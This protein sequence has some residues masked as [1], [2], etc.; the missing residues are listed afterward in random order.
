[1]KEEI[2]LGID[3]GTR[4]TGYGVIR[5][6]GSK[7]EL[8]DFGCIKP[9]PTLPL[10][11]RYLYLFNGVEELVEKYCPTSLSVENQFV[12]KNIQSAMKLGMARCAVILAATRRS[13]PVF[14]YAPK[15]AKLSVV[16][17]GD[18]TKEQVQ[19]MLQ[20][21]LS[22]DKPPEPEDASDALALAI[23]HANSLAA[24]MQEIIYQ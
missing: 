24:R 23:C 22:L 15:S 21:L 3:P 17:R 11:E 18:A 5:V 12:K 8:I 7:M 13:I 1:M 4:V 16:G 14:E 9:K 10:N 19:K 2:I 6:L 20:M